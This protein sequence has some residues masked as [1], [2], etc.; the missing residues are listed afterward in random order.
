MIELIVDQTGYPQETITSDL[1]LL[2]DLNLDSIKAGELVASAAQQAGVSG[3]LDPSTLA[4]ATIK[5]VA[6]TIESLIDDFAVVTESNTVGAEI[7]TV[8]TPSIDMVQLLLTLVEEQTGFPQN[9]LS[10][11]LKLLDDLN[12]DSIKAG[13]LVADAAQKV[14]VSG[15][16]DPSALAN[17]TIAEIA[18]VL[19]DASATN[20]PVVTKSQ[21][22]AIQ[23]KTQPKKQSQEEES[24]VRNFKVEYIA[25]EKTTS[26]DANW[27]V[28]RVL[29]VCDRS[30]SSFVSSLKAELEKQKAGVTLVGYEELDKLDGY[31]HY[32]AFLP[33]IAQD[34]STL[35][36]E[37]MTSRLKSIATAPKNTSI[38]YVQF[39]GGRFGTVGSNIHPEVCNAAAFARSVHLERNDLKVRVVDLDNR[40]DADKASEL[41]LQEIPSEESIITADTT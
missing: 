19:K 11:D 20:V 25:R 28:A 21:P 9:T 35:S 39:G 5:E 1:Q 30:D 16:L 41:I 7:E 26:V 37:S 14:G 22:K 4:N 29:I 32:I 31:S 2:D 40:I 12:L 8:I 38:T 15:E 33:E 23:L 3:E 18:Q 27:S 24:W 17:A 10:P 36:L 13:E 6:E 34:D